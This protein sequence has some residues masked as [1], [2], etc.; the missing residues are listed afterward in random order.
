MIIKLHSR[1]RSF[2]GIVNY[3]MHDKEGAKTS[4]RMAWTHTLNLANDHVASAVNEMIWT[5]RS[6]DQLKRA[7]GVKTSGSK[8]DRPVKHFSL[9]WHASESP[10]KEEMIDFTKRYLKH[11]GMDDR[12]AILFAHNDTAHAHVHVVMKCR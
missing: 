9:S 7:A 3:L 1:G 6:A 10:T 12:Q 2:K 8:L 11:M 5:C 4:E